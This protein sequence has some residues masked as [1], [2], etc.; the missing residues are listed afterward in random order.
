M[1]SVGAQLGIQQTNFAGSGV[2]QNRH[3]VGIAAGFTLSYGL[4][5]KLGLESGVF[6]SHE[7]IRVTPLIDRRYEHANYIQIPLALSYWPVSRLRLFAGPQVGILASATQE[8]SGE[9][10]RNQVSYKNMALSA[11]AGMG[12]QLFPRWEVQA[13][14]QLGITRITQE[15]L[16]A[17]YS[18]ASQIGVVYWLRNGL[19]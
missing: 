5:K 9:R 12:Y 19:R 11:V 1:L 7:G 8:I 17:A 13:R 18:R 6:F 16:A 4:N 15:P 14:M 3:D 10:F 2:V